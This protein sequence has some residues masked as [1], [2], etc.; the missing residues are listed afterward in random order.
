MA[1]R[2]SLNSS[3]NDNPDPAP[4]NAKSLRKY[5]IGMYACGA[6]TIIFVIL[7]SISA[8][9]LGKLINSEARKGVVMTSDTEDLWAHIPGATKT[10]TVRNFTFFNFTNPKEVLYRKAKP[11]F[12]EISGYKYQ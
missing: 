7:A 10:F 6:C 11:V 2:E 5:K 9:I 1:T 8:L 3:I 4:S 12:R